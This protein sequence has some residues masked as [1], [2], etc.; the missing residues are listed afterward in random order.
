MAATVF[1]SSIKIIGA[2]SA[3]IVAFCLTFHVLFLNQVRID[4]FIIII[5]DNDIFILTTT[6]AT[7]TLTTI[8]TTPTAATT[9]ATTARGHY[10]LV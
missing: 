5:V 9:A 2:Y 8:T 1:W 6:T 10:I 4:F 3:F 7:A